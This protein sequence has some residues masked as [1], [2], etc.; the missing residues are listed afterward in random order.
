M[1]TLFKKDVIPQFNDIHG[2]LPH[3]CPAP[4][5]LYYICLFV[6]ECCIAPSGGK[7]A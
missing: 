7:T 4:I 2:L 3:N 5:S 6:F 1:C